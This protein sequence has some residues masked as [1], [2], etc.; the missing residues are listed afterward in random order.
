MENAYP[1]KTSRLCTA[2]VSANTLINGKFHLLTL[3]VAGAAAKIFA[4]TIP[5]Q[6][7]EL[8][9][10]N[11]AKP[12]EDVIPERLIDNS[13]RN[14]MLRRPFSFA[15]VVIRPDFVQLDIIYSVLGPATLR[16]TTIRAG[17]QMSIIGPLGNGF[18]VSPQKATAL[19]LAGGMGAPPIYHL[20]KYIKKRHNNIKIVTFTGAKTADDLLFKPVSDKNS[21]TA[22]DDGSE[23]FN[24]FVT[25]S[26]EQWLN[27]SRP[28]VEETAIYACGPEPMLAKT[29]EIADKMQIDCQL[30]LERMM[31]CGIGLCQSCAV[32]CKARNPNEK[33]SKLCCKD[34]PVFDSREI[35]W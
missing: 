12:A 19:L 7:I 2:T 9:V 11:L 27:D 14:I 15:D 6:F 32:N 34:G 31:A 13:R 30:S 3:K 10:E 8:S 28:A 22:T 16:M 17:E 5:G 23:G 21:F 35:I 20:A 1:D 26:M 25:D 33:T 4:N 18:S 24:G 29:A